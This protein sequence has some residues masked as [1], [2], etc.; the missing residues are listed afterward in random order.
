MCENIKLKLNP[1]HHGASL[2]LNCAVRESLLDADLLEFWSAPLDLG[3]VA[4]GLIVGVALLAAHAAALIGHPAALIHLEAALTCHNGIRELVIGDNMMAG[5][6]YS[7][8]PAP[9]GLVQRLARGGGHGLARGEL[10]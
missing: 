3:A 2:L 7:L 10:R 8:A 1:T 9:R 6:T 4:D 5:L